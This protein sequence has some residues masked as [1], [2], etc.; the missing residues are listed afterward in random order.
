M[1][2][3]F[4][5]STHVCKSACVSSFHGVRLMSVG[6]DDQAWKVQKIEIWKIWPCHDQLQVRSLANPNDIVVLP[7][8]RFLHDLSYF[9]FRVHVFVVDD[10]LILDDGEPWRPVVLGLPQLDQDGQARAYAIAFGE[11]RQHGDPFEY[12]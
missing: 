4:V 9:L 8:D 12:R 7:F 3:P 10:F 11:Q 1:A 6:V 5:L 2:R